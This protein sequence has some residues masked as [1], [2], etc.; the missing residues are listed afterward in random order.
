MAMTGNSPDP[1]LSS[2][3]TTTIEVEKQMNLAAVL[4]FYRDTDLRMREVLEDVA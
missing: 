1:L 4:P 3:H 2:S